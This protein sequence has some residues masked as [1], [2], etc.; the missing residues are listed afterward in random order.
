L[1]RI[2]VSISP[3]R[4]SGGSKKPESL[5][6]RS[7]AAFT[8]TRGQVFCGQGLSLLREIDPQASFPWPDEILRKMHASDDLTA[9]GIPQGGALSCFLTNVVPDEADRAIE[10]LREPGGLEI[11]NLRY[12]DDLMI[13]SPDSAACQEGFGKCPSTHPVSRN[14]IATAT[15]NCGGSVIA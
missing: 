10:H 9:I 1:E 14:W 2:L 4:R 6:L 12:C 7:S 3:N 5:I 15:A 8:L 11:E 13:L